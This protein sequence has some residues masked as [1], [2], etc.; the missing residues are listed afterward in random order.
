MSRRRF[1]LSVLAALYFG[2]I[3]GL[4]FVPDPSGNRPAWFWP[5]VTF[6][7]VGAIL[8]LLLGGRRWWVAIGFAVLG[9]AWIE[10]AQSIWMPVGYAEVT[11]IAWA[12]AGAIAGVILGTLLDLP[13]RRSIHAHEPHRIVTQ[14]GRRE[15]PQ[16]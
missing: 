12:S 14:A 9:A 16:D 8:R 1:L 15:I 4:C 5:L 3:A 2:A 10:T 11:D 13:R 6:V 7:P